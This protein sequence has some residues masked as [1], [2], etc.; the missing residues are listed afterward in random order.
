MTNR[1]ELTPY[2]RELM[3]DPVHHRGYTPDDDVPEP[4]E[5]PSEP[6]G[7][8]KVAPRSGENSEPSA[9]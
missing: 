2:E 8:S 1:R 7:A 6:A 3:S 9:S 4:T 5:A